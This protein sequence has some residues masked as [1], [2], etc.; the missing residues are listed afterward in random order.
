M[1]RSLPG[2][3]LACFAAA[4]AALALAACNRPPAPP[5]GAVE[6]YAMR[7]EVVRMPAQ[8]THE[9]VIRHEAVPDFRDD[10]GQVVGMEAMTMPF[11]LAPDLPASATEGLK[12]GDRIA[13]TLETRWQDPTDV[14]RIARIDRLPEGTPLAWDPPPGDAAKTPAG[15][16]P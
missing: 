16:P 8:A 14:A 7:G 9:I 15:T 4:G 10:R 11:S 1:L 12:P 13:F 3:R 5:A 2:R 6:S